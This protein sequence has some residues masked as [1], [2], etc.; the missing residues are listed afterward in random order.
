LDTLILKPLDDVIDGMLYDEATD[1]YKIF[2][3]VL[4]EG[5][6]RSNEGRGGKG[7]GA[8]GA[9]TFQGIIPYFYDQLQPGTAI[10]MTIH[11]TRRL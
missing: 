8:Y 2:C 3:N 11:M 5:N 9:L 6:Y 4:K 7:Y 1:T 10:E